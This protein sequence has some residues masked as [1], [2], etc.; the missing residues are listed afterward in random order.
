MAIAILHRLLASIPSRNRAIA[1]YLISKGARPSMFSATMLGQLEVVKAFLAAHPGAQ[2]IRGPH[3]IA[4]LAHARLGGEGARPVFDYL[5][6][7]GDAGPDAL[8][9][10]SDSDADALKGTYVFGAD[11]TEQIEVTVDR[12]QLLWTRKGKVARPIYP[13]GDRAFYP[14][15]ASAVRIH[16]TGEGAS[17]LMTV[18][19]PEVVLVARR[20]QDPK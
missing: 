7:L 14:A 5:Q 17:M 10:L 4:L 6:A 20:K 11:V 15:G 1:E 3:G 12:G 9:A 8:V 2:R 13:V 18:N 19:D 16:F